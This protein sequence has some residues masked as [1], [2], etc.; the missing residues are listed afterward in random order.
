M[1]CLEL[2]IILII[3]PVLLFLTFHFLIAEDNL[4]LCQRI[5]NICGKNIQ[6]SD[7]D[8]K[9]KGDKIRKRFYFLFL[10][11]VFQLFF[12]F[13]M[14][15]E[16]SLS[17]KE[18]YSFFLVLFT[19]IAFAWWMYLFKDFKKIN[20]SERFFILCIGVAFIASYMTANN[21]DFLLNRNKYLFNIF[22]VSLPLFLGYIF[23]SNTEENK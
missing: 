5:H 10:F 22:I 23:S 6:D 7:G 2:I 8:K 3:E 21:L 20:G 11:H 14:G 18:I 16:F 12:I 15:R 4:T 19:M 9:I 13:V 1:S 17:Y